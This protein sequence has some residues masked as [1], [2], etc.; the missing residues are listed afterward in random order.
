M[1]F[2]L[3]HSNQVRL[4]AQGLASSAQSGGLAARRGELAE[5]VMRDPGRAVELLVALADLS[6][7]ALAPVEV[8]VEDE[9][10]RRDRCRKAHAAYQRGLR[11]KWVVDGEREYQREKK[12]C[13]RTQQRQIRAG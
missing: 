5:L 11:L 10:A 13:Y 4:Q 9:D 6:G 1:I 3:V 12:R 7:S 2:T 8:D